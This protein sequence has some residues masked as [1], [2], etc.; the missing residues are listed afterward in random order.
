MGSKAAEYLEDKIGCKCASRWPTHAKREGRK[1]IDDLIAQLNPSD[2]PEYEG[3]TEESLE[4]WLDNIAKMLQRRALDADHAIL[5]NLIFKALPPQYQA[6]AQQVEPTEELEDYIDGIA[7][8]LYPMST[9]LT[10]T[11]RSL[12]EYTS[13]D[14]QNIVYKVTSRCQ[15]YQRLCHRRNPDKDHYM[16]K[17]TAYHIGNALKPHLPAWAQAKLNLTK[18]ADK[19]IDQ[20]IRIQADLAAR[21]M[22]ESEIHTVEQIE[23]VDFEVNDTVCAGCHGKH[24]RKHCPF[25]SAH[26][27]NCGRPGHI[28]RACNNIVH[29]D[30]FGQTHVME[31]KRGGALVHHTP[32]QPSHNSKLTALSQATAEEAKYHEQRNRGQQ[33]RQRRK[34]DEKD[35]GLIAQQV[36]L[37]KRLG[38]ASGTDPKAKEVFMKSLRAMKRYLDPEPVAE[39]DTD[40]LEVID[41]DEGDDTAR[42]FEVNVFFE[43][44]MTPAFLDTG[45]DVCTLNRTSGRFLMAQKPDGYIRISCAAGVQRVPVYERVRLQIEDKEFIVPVCIANRTEGRNL[46]SRQIALKVRPALCP[47]L[48]VDDNSLD[49]IRLLEDRYKLNPAPLEATDNFPKQKQIFFEKNQ[50]LPVSLRERTWK[51]LEDFKEVWEFPKP[52]Q[53]QYKANFRVTGKPRR[54]KL[55]H[56]EKRM[57]D[58]LKAHIDDQLARG[59]IRPSNSAWA[60]AP[61]FVVKKTGELR[62]V[63][64]YR[65]LN[66]SMITDS[67]PLPRLWSNVRSMAGK[68]F[69]ITLDMASGFWNVPLTEESKPLTAFIT[70]FGLYESNVVPFGI[71]NSPSEFQRAM[72]NAFRP[73][74]GKSVSC[75]VDD[76]II[77]ADSANEAL[78]LLHKFLDLCRS[79]GFYVRLDKCEFLKSEVDYLGF[80]VG[81]DGVKAILKRTNQIRNAAVPTTKTELRSFL[82]VAGQL[83]KFVPAYAE[84]TAPFTDLLK[85]KAKGL[86]WLPQHDQAFEDLKLAITADSVLRAPIPG[87][88]YIIETDAS[89]RG[90]G[91]VM[92]QLQDG[93]EVI[94]EYASKKFTPTEQRWNTTERELFAIKWAVDYWR[95][96]VVLSKF[97]VRTDHAN[98]R[99]LVNMDKGKVFR[100]AIYLAQY[101][102]DLVFINGQTN[103]VADFL[104][105]H[106]L[107]DEDDDE[108]I[109]TITRSVDCVQSRIILPPLPPFEE[110]VEAGLREFPPEGELNYVILEGVVTHVNKPE[111]WIPPSLRQAFMTKAHFGKRGHCSTNGTQK[112]VKRYGSWLYMKKDIANFCKECPICAMTKNSPRHF[113]NKALGSLDKPFANH[114]VALD[115]IGPILTGGETKY[116]LSMIDHATRFMRTVVVTSLDAETTWQAFD[117]YWVQASFPPRVVLTDGGRAFMGAFHRYVTEELN[118]THKTSA[119]FRP[120]GNGI[121]ERSHSTLQRMT[122]AIA[123]EF[124]VDFAKAVSMATLA[125]NSSYHTAIGMSPYE[126]LYGCLPT[127][128]E[129][130]SMTTLVTEEGRKKVLNLRIQEAAER[131]AMDAA[132]LQPADDLKVGDIV[133][134]WGG[135]QDSAARP[136]IPQ[137]S[138]MTR[139]TAPHWTLPMKVEALTAT[140]VTMR[141]WGTASGIV[142][143]HR[144]QVK[145]YQLPD[146]DNFRALLTSYIHGLVEE[147]TDALLQQNPSRKR[148]IVLNDDSPFAPAQKKS[149]TPARSIHL[150]D[151]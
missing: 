81:Q 133:V 56:Y 130:D 85:G 8:K 21:E 103:N 132:V 29:R 50:D 119:P 139:W 79:T 35:A 112:N 102:F 9:L 87:L 31:P 41:L 84:L 22:A 135:P 117:R 33:K 91:A 78:D 94:V 24:L 67:Y 106:G 151:E 141:R 52:A 4:N 100:W 15:R 72:D 20:L 10:K 97:T 142:T 7:R 120:R 69:Y 55:R 114:T 48:E 86:E 2:W 45:A 80:R 18:S 121:A 107:L 19:L 131:A 6:V 140:Q 144:E 62:L 26:C 145:K 90:I 13:A 150:Q 96:Y 37:F 17:V 54:A 73:L 124:K 136:M 108:L 57:L 138:H 5:R 3:R 127:F 82:G 44:H 47:P 16:G 113:R 70:P 123:L 95:D 122:T 65:L 27:Q 61:H 109:D 89:E 105:R 115:H 98:L 126:A 34:A 128:P 36:E 39:A 93:E 14:L 28:T 116:I 143:R 42:L 149:P 99:Y 110:W 88:P 68:K 30:G 148:K 76:I 74:L 71:K 40:V 104:S 92:K 63:I 43:G 83:R 77:A 38:E 66:E 25:K 146:D 118:A 23:Y 137:L 101:D 49:R 12:L 32:G 60:A 51:I 53:V 125:Y 58:A 75:Y 64:D 1:E 134:A 11:H 46:I 147:Q 129:M 111:L 59:V